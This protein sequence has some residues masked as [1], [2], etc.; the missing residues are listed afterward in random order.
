MDAGAAV[1]TTEGAVVLR[2]R[3]ALRLSYKP[4]IFPLDAAVDEY[5]LSESTP[6][7]DTVGA[8][9]G[10]SPDIL[11]LRGDP[12]STDAEPLTWPCGTLIGPPACRRQW[13][14]GFASDANKPSP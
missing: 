11:R 9:R 14:A 2:L 1:E 5:S 3:Q 8:P 7:R 4:K 6:H 12:G 13:L 10:K